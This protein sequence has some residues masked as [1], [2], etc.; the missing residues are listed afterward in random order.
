MGRITLAFVL[1][2]AC[3]GDDG[4]GGV[5]AAPAGDWQWMDVPAMKCG[6]GSSTGVAIHRGTDPRKLV[7]AFEGGGACWEAAACYG[8]VIQPTSVHLDGF[9]AQTFAG[10]R[11]YFDESWL[12]QRG[13]TSPIRDATWVFVPYCTG[14]LHAGTQTTVYEALGQTRTMHHVGAHNVD[15]LLA[16]VA[17]PAVTEVHAL[18]VSAG[19]Y[20]VQLNWDRIAA[21]F[22]NATTHILADGSQLVPVES[23]RWGAIRQR[24]APRLPCAGCDSLDDV[25]AHLRDATPSGGRH[26][27]LASLQ[28]ATL[29]LFFGYDGAGL[30]AATLPIVNAMTGDAA[31]FQIDDASHT[32]LASP[33]TRTSTGVTLRAWVEAWAT[34]GADFTTVGP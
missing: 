31:A 11:A 9:T 32:M 4:A 2:A 34:G 27:L 17:D 3:G 26:G 22:P 21:A 1:L 29:A 30:R 13:G 20:G 5:D 16:E 6:N 24:W 8:I 28:D 23:A 25:A 14:D 10:V 15:A 18:G 33:N 19:G 7:L 12:F